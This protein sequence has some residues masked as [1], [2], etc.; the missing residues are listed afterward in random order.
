[1]APH[2]YHD[3]M[4]TGGT[5]TAFATRIALVRHGEATSNIER[6]VGGHSAAPLTERGHRQAEAVAARLAASFQPTQLIASDLCR[7]RETA[8]PIISACAQSFTAEP[9]FD[10]RWR[11][12]SLGV[13]DGLDFEQIEAQYGELWRLFRQGD[14]NAVP[15]QAETVDAVFARVGAALGDLV[16]E[17]RGGRVV[18]ISHGIAIFHAIA[19]IFGLGSPSRGLQ[20]FTIVGNAS[21]STVRHHDARWYVEAINDRAHLAALDD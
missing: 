14:P 3:A 11:E 18:V 12:R 17:H 5:E 6:R 10:A 13:L 2:L 4:S 9:E 8:A 20:V 7:T 1:M 16:S 15:P 19:H 21:V